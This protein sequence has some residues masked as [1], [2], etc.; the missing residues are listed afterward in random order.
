MPDIK[1]YRRKDKSIAFI[2]ELMDL[3][4]QAPTF[5]ETGL[6][7]HGQ[8]M[9]SIKI[10]H[11]EYNIVNKIDHV[12]IKPKYWYHDDGSYS[13]SPPPSKTFYSV[14]DALKYLTSH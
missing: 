3:L 7:P 1:F 2:H 14:Q 8:F 12:I 11:R 6:K 9:P 10:G 13:V 4:R 5:S